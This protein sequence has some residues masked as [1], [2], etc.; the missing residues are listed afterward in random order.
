MHVEGAMS[1]PPTI[2]PSRR[3]DL[4]LRPL[5]DGG[6]CVVKDLRTGD[7]FNLGPQESFLLERL[8]G[9]QTATAICKSFETHFGQPLTESELQEFLELARSMGFL[10][11]VGVPG[12]LREDAVITGG[13]QHHVARTKAAPAAVPTPAPPPATRRQTILY[14]SIYIFDP[15]RL[16]NWLEPIIRF[17][18]TR[19]VLLLSAATIVLA[20]LVT[21]ANGQ[22]LVSR[23]SQSLRWETLVVAW[24]TLVIVTT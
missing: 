20:V 24:L 2:P 19:S 1:N 18:W 9:E 10:E 3:N 5:G 23:F 4:L 22:E 13:V 6:D 12:T 16:L 7:Y 11:A 17:V 14:C 21:A 15:D 8:D